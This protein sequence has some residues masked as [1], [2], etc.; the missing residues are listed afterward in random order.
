MFKGIRLRR[1]TS[2]L[3]FEKK[4]CSSKVQLFQRTGIHFVEILPADQIKKDAIKVRNFQKSDLRIVNIWPKLIS[5]STTGTQISVSTASEAVQTVDLIENPQIYQTSIVKSEEIKANSV[6]KSDEFQRGPKVKDLVNTLEAELGNMHLFPKIRHNSDCNMNERAEIE[7][8]VTRKRLSLDEDLQNATERLIK[9][10]ERLHS[11]G[12]CSNIDLR[13]SNNIE[14]SFAG[15]QTNNCSLTPDQEKL[16]NYRLHENPNS[17]R[18][19]TFYC[20]KNDGDYTESKEFDWLEE[21]RKVAHDEALTPQQGGKELDQI[22][23]IL[24]RQRN[25]LS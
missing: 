22:T 8:R 13:K 14:E 1:K 9:E 4:R 7:P 18:C 24:S 16:E 6:L 19:A 25:G 20:Y 3:S 12:K 15:D 5:K 23:K 10:L 2:T 17:E 11:Q 21:I